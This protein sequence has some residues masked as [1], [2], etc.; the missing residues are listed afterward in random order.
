MRWLPLRLPVPLNQRVTAGTL[1]LVL[2]DGV[3]GPLGDLGIAGNGISGS[4]RLAGGCGQSDTWR[5]AGLETVEHAE[6]ISAKTGTTRCG[7]RNFTEDLLV[8]NAH[9]GL[10]QGKLLLEFVGMGLL[11]LLGL[12]PGLAAGEF[13][14]LPVRCTGGCPLLVS[15]RVATSGQKRGG[16]GRDDDRWD[17]GHT[18]PSTNSAIRFIQPAANAD[19]FGSLVISRPRWRRRCPSTLP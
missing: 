2:F 7:G 3:K 9:V 10:C 15:D 12:L 11:A 13:S 4:S 16:E 14:G 18:A 5:S 8:A 6:S 1:A 19:C 17:R